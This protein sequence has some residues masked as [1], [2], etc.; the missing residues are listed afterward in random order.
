MLILFNYESG[1]EF[2]LYLYSGSWQMPNYRRWGIYAGSAFVT[3]I[4]QGSSGPD[5]RYLTGNL[6]PKADTWY[7]L[8]LA[9]GKEAGFVAQ[10]WERDNSSRQAEYRRTFGEEW[11]GRTWGFMIGAN[12]GKIYVDSFTEISFSGIK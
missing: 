1:A 5:T 7:Y 11:A 6:S 8:L 12:A 4:W 9:V 3:N 10:V 2:E